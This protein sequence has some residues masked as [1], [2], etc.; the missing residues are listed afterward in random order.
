MLLSCF[1]RLSLATTSRQAS[2]ALFALSQ[3]A[4]ETNLLLSTLSQACQIAKI[5]GCRVIAV[6]GG[7]DKCR[8]LKEEL[9]VD[10]A[11]DYKSKDFKKDFRETV[12]YFDAVI[13]GYYHLFAESADADE[14]SSA[15]RCS[16]MSVERSLTSLLLA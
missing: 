1:P 9:G 12:G 10:A 3:S 11:L 6:A 7:A 8:W 13:F 15:R 5:K 16:T 2:T 14:F 4:S